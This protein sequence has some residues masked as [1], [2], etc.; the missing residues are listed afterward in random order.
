MLESKSRPTSLFGFPPALASETILL[1]PQYSKT[2]MKRNPI[3]FFLVSS[4]QSTSL[5][6]WINYFPPL[7]SFAIPNVKSMELP[8][9]S[10][11]APTIAL[12]ADCIHSHS[13]LS[14]GVSK[15]SLIHQLAENFENFI[16]NAQRPQKKSFDRC[17]YYGAQQLHTSECFRA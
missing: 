5:A 8:K 6:R 17:N 9:L 4:P 10:Q 16:M 11:N 12:S 14:G 15:T 1:Y 3:L 13:I 2:T 7:I